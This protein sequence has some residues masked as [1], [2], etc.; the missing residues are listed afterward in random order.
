[1]K[2]NRI[3][4]LLF[5]I[6]NS[7]LLFASSITFNGGYTKISMKEGLESITLENPANVV[8]D[9]L[10]L[11]ATKISLLGKNY[12]KIQCDGTV[13]I[14][15]PTKG[16]TI[17]C[18]SLFYNRIT[19][20]ITITGGVEID[21]T[22]NELHS[23]SQSLEYDIDKKKMTISVEI[24]LLHI[25]DNNVMK[26]SGDNLI[27]NRGEN[28]LVLLGNSTVTWKDDEYRAEAISVNMNNNEISLEGSIEGSIKN[29]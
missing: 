27:F 17:L 19:N 24:N 7:S 9:D 4:C 25:A 16:L 6:I 14:K 1:M 20:I 13:V 2:R 10:S 22:K 28:T 3:I 18:N 15:D 21:D 5:I 12:D 29:T 8:I 23:T 26:C 11:S